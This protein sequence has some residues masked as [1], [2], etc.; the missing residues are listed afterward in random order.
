M[1][2]LDGW[3]VLAALK[4]DP[5]L[6]DIPAILVT[7]LD[8]RTKGYSL[9]A[10]DYVVKPVERDRLIQLLRAIGDRGAGRLL[11]VE[12]DDATRGAIHRALE[13]EGWA[14]V[15]AENGRVALERVADVRPDCIVLDLIMP[16][17][18]EF[19][20]LAE[21]LRGPARPGDRSQARRRRR[22]APH[23]HGG[24]LRG[25]RRRPRGVSR[26]S[27]RER[28]AAAGLA[29]TLRRVFAP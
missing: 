25:P 20:F 27:A 1:P 24:H 11:L 26:R 17:M 9:G 21:L 6:A 16:E 8:E 15:E 23:R 3:T 22:G 7:I 5:S 19:E 10:T 14:V 12:D 29:R 4:G 18:D 2:D 28:E 13:R